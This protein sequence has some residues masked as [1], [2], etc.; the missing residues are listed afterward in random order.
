MHKRCITNQARKICHWKVS[1]KKLLASDSMEMQ[2]QGPAGR[3]VGRDHS[4]YSKPATHAKL[5]WKSQRSFLVSAEK[6]VPGR[7]SSEDMY[8]NVLPK[9]LCRTLHWVVFWIELHKNELLEVKVTIDFQRQRCKNLISV[10]CVNCSGC[11]VTTNFEILASKFPI[12]VS[13]SKYT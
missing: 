6:A 4:I 2:V 5:A 13:G 10:Q 8:Y 3:L 1:M 9:M 12:V 11:I 7:E